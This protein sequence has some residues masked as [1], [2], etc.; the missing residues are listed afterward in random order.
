MFVNTAPG[1]FQLLM[2]KS[3]I[4]ADYSPEGG[5][6]C[7]PVSLIHRKPTWVP[8]LSPSLTCEKKASGWHEVQGVVTASSWM[9]SGR[10]PPL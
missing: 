8:K 1:V 9:F 4:Q 6:V 2:I 3:R 7:S 5:R 10:T